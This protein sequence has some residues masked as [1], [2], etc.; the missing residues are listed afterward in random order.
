MWHIGSFQGSQDAKDD[1]KEAAVVYGE[2]LEG[3]D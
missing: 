2:K 1:C 3:W